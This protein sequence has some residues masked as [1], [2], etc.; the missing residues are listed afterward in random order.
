MQGQKTLL[1]VEA[2]IK[3]MTD[4]SKEMGLVIE[5]EEDRRRKPMG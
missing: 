3:V 2:Y 5:F 4:N 1:H